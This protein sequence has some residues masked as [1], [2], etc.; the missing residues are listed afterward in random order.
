MVRFSSADPRTAARGEWLFDRIVATG[1]LVV[2][3]LGGGRHGEVAAHRYLSSPYV[4]AELILDALSDRTRLAVAGC[5]VVVAQDTTEINFS[6]RGAARR[7]LGPGGDGESRGFFIHP[8]VAI[9]ADQE[10]LL[11][12]VGGEIWTRAEGKV[13][14]RHQR[15]AED[16]E[17]RRWVQGSRKAASL[18]GHARQ[19]IDV[20]DREGDVWAHIAH[21][22]HGVDLASRARHDR[23]LEGGAT[24]FTALAEQPPLATTLVRVSPQKIGEKARTAEVIV[25]AGKVRITRP[26]RAPRTDP[27]VLEMGLV[28]AI[29]RDP[30]AG[31]E[32]LLWR[33]LT[34]LPVGDAQAAQEV[35]RLY[36]LRWRIE[37]VFRALKKD[38]L[39]L[40]DTQVQDGERLFRLAALAL[41]A[42][43][44]IL[45]LVDARDGG[46][47]PMS[48]VL[49]QSLT[50]LV[51]ILVRDRE[52]PT[53]KQQNPHPEGSLAW[54]SWVV[55]RYGGWNCYGK[56]PGPKTM[57][58]GWQKLS[59]TLTGV[60]LAKALEL[61]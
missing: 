2:R 54:L 17:S 37:E 16:K 8:S 46:S 19:V 40:E 30:P 53:A 57:A 5:R 58:R 38:G 45:Q 7:G 47:R 61:P 49:D 23:P 29:E 60:I 12:L 42:A 1:S 41:G 43:V 27:K 59:A 33:I 13:G 22:P 20:S 35:V 34:T 55:A 28:E 52:R 44:R 50:P 51:A 48:D 25:R 39:A 4:S 24:L 11:G 9:D 56:P 26:A 36:R 15:A 18:V 3:E 6:G 10:T 31:T 32:P 14:P 21:L